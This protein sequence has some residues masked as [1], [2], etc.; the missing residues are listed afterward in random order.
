MPLLSRCK[1]HDVPWPGPLAS[2]PP[3]TPL[4]SMHFVLAECF[5]GLER[6]FENPVIQLWNTNS[7]P[8][9]II[10][11]CCCL[12]AQVILYLL[13]VLPPFQ[14]PLGVTFHTVTVSGDFSAPL[15]PLEISLRRGAWLLLSGLTVLPACCRSLPWGF[16]ALPGILFAFLLI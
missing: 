13:L 14:Q 11:F 16:T 10:A 1:R 2:F 5:W 9:L 12:L 4:F 7:I 3:P 8:K 6:P 15:F